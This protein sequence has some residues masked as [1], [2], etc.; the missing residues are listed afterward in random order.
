MFYGFPV[1]SQVLCYFTPITLFSPYNHIKITQP[2]HFQMSKLRLRGVGEVA[3][4][5]HTVYN[6]QNL[7]A[8]HCYQGRRSACAV[9]YRSCWCGVQSLHLLGP[10]SCPGGKDSL[11]A[12]SL[13]A[14]QLLYLP[15]LQPPCLS[16]LFSPISFHQVS[17]STSWGFS[18]DSVP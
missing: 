18:T 6:W 3:C 2:T 16:Q 7:E 11:P 13:R 8:G 15:G 4:P 10:A 9:G 5:I 14:N 1:M 12:A 17:F